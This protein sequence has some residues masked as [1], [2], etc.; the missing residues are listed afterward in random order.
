MRLMTI[1]TVLIFLAFFLSAAPIPQ[2]GPPDGGDDDDTQNILQVLVN[3]SCDGNVVSVTAKGE[4]VSGA[5]VSVKDVPTANLVDSGDTGDDGQFIFDGCGMKVDVKVASSGYPSETVTLE[6]IDCGQCSPPQLPEEEQPPEE[7]GCS[8]NLDCSQTQYCNMPTNNTG[9]CEDVPAGGCGQISNHSFVAYGYECGTEDGC[10]SCQ[11]GYECINHKCVQGEVICPTEGIVGDNKTCGATENG[12]PC[13]NCDYVVTDPSG[14]NST[15]TTDEN[16]T[17]SFPLSLQGTYKVALLKDGLTLK[18]IEVKAMP[19]AQSEEP[20]K[21]TGAS[22]DIM[23]IVI[24]ISLLL[25]LALAIF[26]W[27]KRAATK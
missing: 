25:L 7:G 19:K 11:E 24:G 4:N 26:F 10:P 8:S 23:P 22:S 9:S 18:I 3:P 5:H 14:K 12:Q 1:F 2:P 6:L 20:D 17:I 27:R 13:A 21:P 15:G 16:G